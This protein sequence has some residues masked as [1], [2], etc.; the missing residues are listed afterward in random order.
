[1]TARLHLA[2][3]AHLLACRFCGGNRHVRG[4]RV[5]YWGFVVWPHQ[6][7]KGASTVKVHIAG[8]ALLL[9]VVAGI[10]RANAVE[11]RNESEK[12]Q[13]LAANGDTD[14]AVT[15]IFLDRLRN[16]NLWVRVTNHGPRVVQGRTAEL[17]VVVDGG[18]LLISGKV[19]VRPGQTQ[20][21]NTGIVVDA[22]QRSRDITVTVRVP[23]MR[24]LRPSN[25]TY[26]E[27]VP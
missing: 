19:S 2:R 7:E 26:R 1:M 10:D 21:I 16:G 6:S 3:A 15:D 22:S 13:L 11:P 12:P 24:D 20:T 18:G 27:V 8:A 17:I 5:R 25:N 23:G 9:C 14:L 4:R